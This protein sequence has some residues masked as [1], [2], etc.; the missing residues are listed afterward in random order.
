MAWV[1]HIS[2]RTRQYLLLAGIL[3]MAALV[4]QCRMVTDATVRPQITTLSAGNCISEC[5]KS[6]NEAMRAESRRH[7][8]NIKACRSKECKQE[9][10]RRHVAAVHQIQ[11]QRQACSAS[12]HHQGGGKG[13]R[14]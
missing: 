11:E 4:T 2:R 6:A 10:A 5:N 9:E 3:L 13:G 1:P 8:S 12:C 7:T 14:R